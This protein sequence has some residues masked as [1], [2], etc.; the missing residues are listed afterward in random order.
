MLSLYLIGMVRTP[1]NSYKENNVFLFCVVAI[2]EFASADY[3]VEE[4]N[5]INV[6]VTVTGTLSDDVQL[7]VYTVSGTAGGK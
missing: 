7:R 3:T 1:V 6:V 2:V 5:S 4:E